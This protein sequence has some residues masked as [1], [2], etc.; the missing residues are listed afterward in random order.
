MWAIVTGGIVF[1]LTIVF[2]LG[3]A[4]SKREKVA[5]GHREELLARQEKRAAD[6]VVIEP[7]QQNVKVEKKM[8]PEK[9]IYKESN[10]KHP[11]ELH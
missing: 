9:K 8:I 6:D 4:S 2:S 10:T 5:H 7:E 11:S 3:K 1:M